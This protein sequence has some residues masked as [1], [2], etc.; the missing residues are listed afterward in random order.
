[1]KE[2]VKDPQSLSP[3]FSN[4][5]LRKKTRFK[6]LFSTTDA[7]A[8]FHHARTPQCHRSCIHIYV[9]VHT[10]IRTAVSHATVRFVGLFN[11]H[12][13]RFPTPSFFRPEHSKNIV[14]SNC[15]INYY[16]DDVGIYS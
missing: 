4:F 8:L 12:K 13:E 9:R 1:M 10:Y 16:F 11:A 2:S 7:D 3:E 5:F 15:G 14:R 6:S